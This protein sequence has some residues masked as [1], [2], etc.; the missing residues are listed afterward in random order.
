MVKGLEPDEQL[1]MEKLFIERKEIFYKAARKYTSSEYDA[2]DVIHEALERVMANVVTIRGLNEAAQTAYVVI[3][4]KN[5]AI[6]HR[7]K[8]AK[9]RCNSTYLDE[10][11]YEL[12]T[13]D[14]KSGLDQV[15]IEQEMVI[16][17][18]EEWSG[19]DED[20]RSLLEQKYI[21]KMKDSEIARARGVK[22]SSVRMMLTRARGKLLSQVKEGDAV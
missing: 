1:F 7:K 17:L 22:T 4:I 10:L 19:L 3:A 16:R 8:A 6:S 5:T 20:T 11:G 15:F 18:R 21:M 9:E 14:S 2:E 12:T 13:S